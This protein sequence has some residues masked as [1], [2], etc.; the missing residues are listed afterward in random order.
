[1]KV[2]RAQDTKEEDLPAGSKHIDGDLLWSVVLDKPPLATVAGLAS[3]ERSHGRS[4]MEGKG[5]R[6]YSQY[7]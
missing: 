2:P 6:G 4:N 3:A 1:M 5:R 7:R